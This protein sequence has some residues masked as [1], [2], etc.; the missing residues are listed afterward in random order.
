MAKHTPLTA[1]PSEEWAQRCSAR[2]DWTSGIGHASDRGRECWDLPYRLLLDSRVSERDPS[3]R[4]RRARAAHQIS[5]SAF[6]ATRSHGA[7]P[8]LAKSSAFEEPSAKSR[9]IVTDVMVSAPHT[10]F[11]KAILEDKIALRSQRCAD[12]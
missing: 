6:P 5:Q 8:G 1:R 11:P 7:I 3:D 9:D 4:V 12:T 10:E 2:S